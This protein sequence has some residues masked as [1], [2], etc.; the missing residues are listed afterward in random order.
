MSIK[1]ELGK[2]IKRLRTAYGY[3]QEEL[4]EM[5]DISQRALS[6]IEL[7]KN[8]ATSETLDKILN[9]FNITP[10]ELFATNHLKE[11]DELLK[12]ID[13]NIKEI[14]NNPEKLEIIYNL[15]KSLNKK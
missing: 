9:A 11:A 10:E 15:T 1:K 14:G 7:G 4:S 13:K 6:S 12:M 5:A 8:F 3:T 2:Q